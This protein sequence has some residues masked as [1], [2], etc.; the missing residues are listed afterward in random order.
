MR[1]YQGQLFIFCLASDFSNKIRKWEYILA[2]IQAAEPVENG[3]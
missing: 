3:I 2:P 1:N